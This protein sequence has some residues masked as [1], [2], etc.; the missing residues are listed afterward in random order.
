MLPLRR[1]RTHTLVPCPGK[2]LNHL[3]DVVKG[4][5]ALDAILRR[6][7][8]TSCAGEEQSSFGNTVITQ[9][10][11]IEDSLDLERQSLILARVVCVPSGKVPQLLWVGFLNGANDR[12]ARVSTGQFG[13]TTLHQT[14]FQR[15]LLKGRSSNESSL[16]FRYL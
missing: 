14:E 7:R 6:K 11:R 9:K 2:V 12:S 8:T 3:D 5:I 16:C 10:A 13:L 15:V 4:I 1:A